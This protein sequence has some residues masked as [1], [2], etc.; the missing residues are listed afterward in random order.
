VSGN[1]ADA[2]VD[3]HWAVAA[4]SRNWGATAVS[5]HQA[6]EVVSGCRGVAILY[7]HHVVVAVLV[8]NN[9]TLD[10]AESAAVLASQTGGISATV[11]LR[12]LM[13][14]L[15]GRQTTTSL[16]P[17]CGRGMAHDA[18]GAQR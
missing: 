17:G 5:R 7:G 8:C 12:W 9:V 15:V 14:S 16:G 2:A 11:A 4:L 13:T 18:E 10:T 3:G 1:R 6:M